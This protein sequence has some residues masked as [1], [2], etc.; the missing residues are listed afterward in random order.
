MIIFEGKFDDDRSSR[1][2][3]LLI[4]PISLIA[5][6]MLASLKYSEEIRSFPVSLAILMICIALGLIIIGPIVIF[7]INKFRN[8]NATVTFSLDGNNLSIMKGRELLRKFSTPITIDITKARINM[9]F[10]AKFYNILVFSDLRYSFAIGEET[11]KGDINEFGDSLQTVELIA[12]DEGALKELE[13]ILRVH[14]PISR[15]STDEEILAAAS[16]G[17]VDTGNSTG[18]STEIPKDINF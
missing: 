17:D 13:S 6:V 14:L 10:G 7:L 8:T 11:T 4:I 3:I 18:N 5:G 1:S 15:S 16:S 12:K 2:N 9:R